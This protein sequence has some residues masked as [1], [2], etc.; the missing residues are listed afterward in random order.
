MKRTVRLQPRKTLILALLCLCPVGCLS[1]EKLNCD[2]QQGRDLATSGCNKRKFQLG[3]TYSYIMRK[4]WYHQI[5]IKN[6]FG[7]IVSDLDCSHQIVDFSTQ[8]G[9][10]TNFLY[11]KLLSE[12]FSAYREN[13]F[14]RR[15]KSTNSWLKYTIARIF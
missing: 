4:V 1:L 2:S 15:T 3:Q 7:F 9:D 5:W 14:D 6:Y 13:P 11:G 12:K 10:L 8:L